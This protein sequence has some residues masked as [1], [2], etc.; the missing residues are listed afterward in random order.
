MMGMVEHDTSPSHINRHGS[1]TCFC[2]DCLTPTTCIC[3]DC[4]CQEQ[5]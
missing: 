4:K 1:C 2:P 5:G 3:R